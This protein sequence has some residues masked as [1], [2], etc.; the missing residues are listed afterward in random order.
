MLGRITLVEAVLL[1]LPLACAFIYKE[2]TIIPF[3]IAI[4]IIKLKSGKIHRIPNAFYP[5]DAVNV[6]SHIK[7][8]KRFK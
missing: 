3:L 4:F 6:L 2:A 7:L 1:L 8:Q 5:M